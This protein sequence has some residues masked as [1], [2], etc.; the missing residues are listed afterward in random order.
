MLVLAHFFGKL[1]DG[2]SFRLDNV[3]YAPIVA[4]NI[5]SPNHVKDFQILSF[6]GKFYRFDNPTLTINRQSTVGEVIGNLQIV[7]VDVRK[8]TSECHSVGGVLSL[9]KPRVYEV[10]DLSDD[11]LANIEMNIDTFAVDDGSSKGDN[12]NLEL[13]SEY[14]WHCRFGHPG[15]AQFNQLRKYHGLP[16]LQHV[17]SQFCQGCMLSKPTMTFPKVSE[18]RTLVTRPF[19]VLHAD[20]CGPV[21]HPIGRDNSHY[22]LVIADRFS[23]RKNVSS[24]RLKS[25]AVEEI[26][27]FINYSFNDFRASHFPKQLRTDNGG[28]FSQ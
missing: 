3:H 1:V 28:E 21:V 12:A 18:G 13:T 11:E 23:Q 9:S 4:A 8:A 5:I 2:T 20:L 17:P 14:E 10:Y 16:N 26:M 27:K 19:E 25:Q 7:G 24:F 6:D 22:F 15:H